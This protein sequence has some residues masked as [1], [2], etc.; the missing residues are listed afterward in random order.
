MK[1]IN[2]ETIGTGAFL[3]GYALWGTASVEAAP[4]R[5]SVPCPIIPTL[6]RYSDSAISP[7]VQQI[8]QMLEQTSR[9]WF[10]TE[11]LA[12]ESEFVESDLMTYAMMAESVGFASPLETMPFR[13]SV[14]SVIEG[15]P[16][17]AT[18]DDFDPELLES[19]SDNI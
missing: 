5:P 7:G 1:R 14:S 3:G 8:S 9:E 17:S 19:L 18:L 11:L 4:V 12:R 15:E 10:E 16:H 13:V 6:N 2:L